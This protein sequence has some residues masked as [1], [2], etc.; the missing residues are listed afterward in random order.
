VIEKK[1]GRKPMEKAITRNNIETRSVAERVEL[2]EDMLSVYKRKASE[3]IGDI[4]FFFKELD[5]RVSKLE[6]NHASICN[7]L[8]EIDS[9][10]RNSWSF[11]IRRLIG[12]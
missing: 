8:E 9:L 7:H 4:N 6:S 1:R 5:N 3:D 12:L 11:R 10:N 2:L